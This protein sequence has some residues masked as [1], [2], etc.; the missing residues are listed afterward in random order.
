M[1]GVHKPYAVPLGCHETSDSPPLYLLFHSICTVK[2]YCNV[3]S[4]HHWLQLFPCLARIC[5]M[6]CLSPQMLNVSVVAS[7]EWAVFQ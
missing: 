4:Q 2:Q 3:D 5:I 7:V 6:E 1:A